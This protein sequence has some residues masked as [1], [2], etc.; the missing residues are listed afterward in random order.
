MRRAGTGTPAH[1]PRAG[2]PAADSASVLGPAADLRRALRCA[3]HPFPC[4]LDAPVRLVLVLA[5][6]HGLV[7]GL[8]ELVETAVHYAVEGHLAHSDADSCD[9]GEAGREHGCG[10]AQHLCGCCASQVFV[11]QPPSSPLGALGS[12]EPRPAD[13]SRLVSLHDPAPPRR[14]PIAS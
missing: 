13:L 6:I 9:P 10:G 1:A 5:L 14:P 11:A 7:P 2:R 8:G 3:S 4:R 12:R